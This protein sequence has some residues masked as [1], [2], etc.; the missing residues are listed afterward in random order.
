V[1]RLALFLVL[2]SM[3]FAAVDGV[4]VN[5]TTGKPQ[6]GVVVTLYQL[7][8]SGMQPV[9]TVKSDAQGVFRIDHAVQ[10][11]HLV[12]TIYDG[13]VYNRMLQPG[14]AT[15]NLELEVYNSSPKPAGA[16]IAQH[17]VLLEPLGGILHV[18]E[19]VI[20]RN[21]GNLTY[22]DPANGTLRVFLPEDVKGDPRV[23]ITAPQGMPVERSAAA[24]GTPNVYKVDFPV[25][26]GETRF[27]L[28]YVLPLPESK[29]YSGRI[30]HDGGAVRIVAP[31]GVT[32]NGPN[33][34]MIGREPT[35]QATVYQVKGKEYSLEI[36]GAGQLE[37]PESA[38]QGGGRGIQTISARVYDQIFA[39]IG[40]AFL[41]LLLG[42][43]LLYR[44]GAATGAK[45]R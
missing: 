15:S 29:T 30:L 9:R 5:R 27:D 6:P 14:G 45:N 40:L 10:G 25:K 21:E 24:T 23:M 16:Q 42:F 1:R 13:V 20:F 31:R 12:Q 35:T 8:G 19:S 2:P 37:S 26:P 38:G 33:I 34:E 4:V 44:R 28:T 18:N 41:V 39:I 36:E 22:N 7:A 17:M 32:L 3:A 11:P 43:I